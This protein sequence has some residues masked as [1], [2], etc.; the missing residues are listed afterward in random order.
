MSNVIMA[1]VQKSKKYPNRKQVLPWTEKASE[2][3]LGLKKQ[4]N[5]D[6]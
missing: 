6:V 1:L 2:V 5:I 4:K 3:S